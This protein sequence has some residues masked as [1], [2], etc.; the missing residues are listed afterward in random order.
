M[1]TIDRLEAALRV[2]LDEAK[3]NADFRARLEAAL[4]GPSAGGG[5]KR[6]HRRAQSPVDPF[7]VFETDG[8][9]GLRTALGRLDL[10]QLKDVVAGYDMDRDRLALKWRSPDRLIARIVDLVAARRRKGD[11]FLGEP[12]AGGGKPDA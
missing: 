11:A 1:S 3:E 2:V 10:E 6:R 4:S 5:E 7:R 9:A 8:E 12:A